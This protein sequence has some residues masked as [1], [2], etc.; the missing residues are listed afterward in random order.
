MHHITESAHHLG[1]RDY[2]FLIVD[3]DFEAR[4]FF[5]EYLSNAFDSKVNLFEADTG[6]SGLSAFKQ[7]E[8]DCLLI[9]HN[10]PD[11]DS[12]GFLNR[13][14]PIV[15]SLFEVP[16][17]LI[18]NDG[19]EN[20]AVKALRRG[21]E[22]YLKKDEVTE[23]LLHS[24][25]VHAMDTAQLHKEV[26][27]KRGEL[28]TFA[29]TAAHDLKS[30]LSR[31]NGYSSYLMRREHNL[32]SKG[33]EAL[34]NITTSA[35]SMAG[36]INGLL[37]YTRTARSKKT[38]ESVNL[39]QTIEK[40]LTDVEAQADQCLAQFSI[41]PLPT[42]YGDALALA[43]LFQ[44]LI[45]NAMKFCEGQ[46]EIFIS[47]IEEDSLWHISVKDNGIGIPQEHLKDAFL[48][49]QRCHTGHKYEGTGLGLALCNSIIL[50]H[51][52]RTWLEST[53]GK[54]T[55]VHFTIPNAIPS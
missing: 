15:H 35:A 41:D 3:A 13:L 28:E 46:P 27:E 19:D 53:V 37:E 34:E 47:A 24:C 45:T 5:S 48:P 9:E 43:Q 20:L 50:Q 17:V 12:L 22:D 14:E 26:E 10:L 42:I 33:K 39:N 8:I 52:G 38:L 16:I 29:S 31:I 49:L 4:Q 25:V 11:M 18:T 23:E 55:T 54:G 30:P 1:R 40:V 7:Q 32:S 6:E 51:H 44:N 36:L 2:R 21:V